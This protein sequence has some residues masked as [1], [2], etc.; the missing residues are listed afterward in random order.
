MW[1]SVCLGWTLRG[2]SINLHWRVGLFM[3]VRF[4]RIYNIVLFSVCRYA[5]PRRSQYIGMHMCNSSRRAGRALL[6]MYVDR[7]PPVRE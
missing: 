4:V 5:L 6:R 1:S 2:G 3:F 7:A